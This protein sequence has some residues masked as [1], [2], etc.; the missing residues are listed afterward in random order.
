LPRKAGKKEKKKGE[1]RESR[2]DWWMEKPAN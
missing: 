2:G 1:R